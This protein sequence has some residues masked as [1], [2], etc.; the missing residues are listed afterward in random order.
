MDFKAE[1]LKMFSEKFGGEPEVLAFSPG[2]VNLI[3]EHID[4]NGGHVFPCALTI[5]NWGA[6]RRRQDGR[7]RFF[8]LN[9]MGIGVIEIDE[10]PL[11][12][13]ARDHWCN[14]PKAMI[15]TLREAG[16]DIKGGMDFMLYGNIPAASGL[17]SSASV[18]LLTGVIVRELWQ[19]AVD[20]E[21]LALLAQ[22]AENE[23]IGVNCGIMDQYAIAMGKADSA[24]LLNTS[25]LD[26]RYAPLHLEDYVLVI[27]SSNKKRGLSHSA[28]NERR[29]ECEEALADLQKAKPGLKHLCELEPEEYKLLE[30][31]IK[32]EVCRKRARH[33]VLEEA[34][35]L[36]AFEALQRSDLRT[37]G[38]LM[39]ASHESL[40]DLYEVS[41]R[42]LDTLVEL[43]LEDKDCLGSRMTG[44]GFG[45]CTVSL[46]K[47]EAAERF[48]TRV[49]EAYKTRIGWAADFYIVVPGDGAKILERIC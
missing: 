34:R 42:E 18:E 23:F 22:K 2:R 28:Y 16:F 17:S 31:Q 37:M 9:F 20:S 29:S 4:Y 15:H 7:L 8:S 45:G 10:A 26:C 32:R 43:A 46:L 38:D 27:A 39:T 24:M 44:A 36:A 11:V 14:Y 21:K 3:G 35:T 19:L 41:C 6:A 49:G 48:I 40:R 47:K 30:P 33:A 12:N 25:N 5:G 13:D 1:L